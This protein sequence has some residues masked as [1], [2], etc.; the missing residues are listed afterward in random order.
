[1]IAFQVLPRSSPEGEKI[2]E[3]DMPGKT[4][5]F[6]DPAEV[7]LGERV[8]VNPSRV[9]GGRS[10]SLAQVLEALRLVPGLDVAECG[11]IPPQ[12][13]AVG[14]EVI[15]FVDD[16]DAWQSCSPSHGGEMVEVIRRVNPPVIFKY[17]YRQGVDYLPGTVSAGYFCVG[18]VRCPPPDLCDRARPIDVSARM[19]TGGYGTPELTCDWLQARG[20]LVEE[21][22]SLVRE[23]WA[24][25]TGKIDRNG[26]YEEL[27]D[28]NFGFNW[29]G[30]GKLT[31]RMIEYIRAG[32]VMI[33][34]PLG[35]RWPVREDIVL[36]DGVHCI[37]CEEPRRFA[38]VARSLRRSPEKIAMIRREVVALWENKLCPGMMGAWYWQ[39]L[40]EG[41][42]RVTP[43]KAR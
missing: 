6:E 11:S 12:C 22:S 40:Q 38:E 42:S 8:L 1:M 25:R 31:Y 16:L 36:E 20:A 28:T 24:T 27:F 34:D 3:M 13:V 17:Q 4:S 2:E 33:T 37:Y 5:N 18:D 19:R 26:Y 39:K 10:G 43:R 15:A 23:G 35:S 32:V 9:E 14:D 41:Q 21:A 7:G 29:R 30:C